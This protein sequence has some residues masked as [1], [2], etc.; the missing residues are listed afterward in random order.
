M[1]NL[2]RRQFLK[3]AGLAGAAAATANVLPGSLRTLVRAQA[4]ETI[5]IGINATIESLDV[6]TAIGPNIIGDRLYGLF[7]DTLVQTN[8]DG[9]LEPML[10][11]A[12]ENDGETAWVFTL[13]DGV[14]FHDGSTMT[15]DDVVYSFERLLDP[16]NESAFSAQMK[17]FVSSVEATGDLEVTFTTPGADP[18]LPYRF[19]NYWASIVP[20]GATEAADPASLMTNP[21]GAGPYKVVSFQTDDRLVLEAHTDYWGGAPAVQEVVVRFLP[22]T[23]TRIAALQAGQVDLISQ[24]P[25]DQVPVLES[26]PGVRVASAPVA[27]YICVHFNTVNGPT[28]DV[29]VRRALS[30]AI[31]REL[32]ADA[33]WNGL[34]RP[35]NDLL[36]PSMFGYDASRPVYTYDPEAARAALAESGYNGEPINF[37][38]T[39]GYYANDAAVM[40][41]ITQMWQDIG[42]NVNLDPLEGSAFLDL[43][44]AGETQA[45]LQSWGGSGDGQFFFET[46]ATDGIFR[47]NYYQPSAE[48]DE[49]LAETSQSFDEDVRYANIRRM[50]ELFEADI[51]FTPVYQNVD[52]FGV[53]EDIQWNPHPGFNI[54][55]RP[56]NLSL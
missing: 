43:Y 46:W 39:A 26:T 49:L 56:Y 45:N 52:I 6:H 41:A 32:I 44:L 20:R 23:A 19:D 47:P 21:I 8:F 31:D 42:V 24:V 4:S 18:L 30:L 55:F 15:A 51:P 28:A 35:M 7:H 10:A 29:N 14:T 33:L 2:S 5:T 11:T 12:W 50:V 22:E 54:D 17:R 37:Q 40:T 3:A 25:V 38:A 36:L 34:S 13:R 48:F 27:N 1:R 9:L 16:A 53:R